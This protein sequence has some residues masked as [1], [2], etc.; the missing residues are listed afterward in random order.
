MLA[1]MEQIQTARPPRSRL[2]ALMNRKLHPA[3][4]LCLGLTPIVL[5]V[6]AFVFELLFSSRPRPA[7]KPAQSALK[8]TM[9]NAKAMFGETGSY[10]F[11]TAFHLSETGLTFIGPYEASQRPKTVSV[12]ATKLTFVA[13][14]KSEGDRCFSIMD[15]ELPGTRF[16]QAND[17]PCTAAN[18]PD[19]FVDQQVE[20]KLPKV[21]S[22]AATKTTFIAAAKSQTGGCFFIIDS[23]PA[24]TRFA[25]TKDRPCAAAEAPGPASALWTEAWPVLVVTD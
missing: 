2:W 15:S 24:G 5:I 9:T 21:V 23:E 13:A 20:S 10:E 3:V 4:A 17:R 16:A 22:V 12:A 18:A 25:E 14:S 19:S 6:V 8:V 7:H 11:A 1:A